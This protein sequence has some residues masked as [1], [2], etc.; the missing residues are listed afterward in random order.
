MNALTHPCIQAAELSCAH[1]VLSCTGNRFIWNAEVPFHE[2]NHTLGCEACFP[3]HN[4]RFI[5]LYFTTLLSRS[6]TIRRAE[7]STCKTNVSYRYLTSRPYVSL[8][9]LILEI[10][11]NVANTLQMRRYG[12]PHIKTGSFPPSLKC[13]T[14]LYPHE[15]Q[16]V[17]SS[18]MTRTFHWVASIVKAVSMLVSKDIREEDMIVLSVS[19][20]RLFLTYND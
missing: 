15:L 19:F 2:I 6:I 1:N 14:P 3:I 12:S 20:S 17:P 18:T 8:Q 4:L 7:E 11:D 10:K 9:L 13:Y 5:R 16:R